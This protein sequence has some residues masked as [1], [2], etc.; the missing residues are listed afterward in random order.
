MA[1][2]STDRNTDR[3]TIT[4]QIAS[5]TQRRER[6]G[7][8]A[9][10]GGVLYLLGAIIL[11]AALSGLPS[12]GLVQGLY[13]ALNGR[14]TTVSPRAAEVSY[15]SKHAFGLIAASVLTAIAVGLLVAVVLFIL[16]ATRFRRP[17]T[18]P[19]ARPAVLVG[20]IAFA[21]LNV[22]HWVAIALQAHSFVKGHDL[23]GK[24]VDR[25][26]LA[27]GGLG[28]TLQAL[29]LFAAL[30]LAV[31]MIAAMVAALR[32]GL[33]PRWL[34]VLGVFSGLLFLPLF[35][36]S[37]FQ[38]IPTFWMVF[39]GILLLGRL[40]GGDP[41]AWAA[42]EARPWPTQA[43]LRAQ[44]EQ[45]AGRDAQREQATTPE[46]AAEP[47]PGPAPEP[48]PG[49]APEPALRSGGARSRRRKRR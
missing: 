32:A 14:A 10:A 1:D 48:A 21:V 18:W 25:A 34:G 12:V 38:L 2:R 22:V 47:A 16:D 28:V 17:Q 37:T 6:L 27:S 5:E 19:A 39:T 20:G 15:L 24:A 40:P 46:P 7:V 41:P 13:P 29:G 31:G 42:G 9:V 11:N 49:P 26:L 30:A 23:S 36:S 33:L 43:E 3:G 35:G 8:P 4:E 45:A 44:R